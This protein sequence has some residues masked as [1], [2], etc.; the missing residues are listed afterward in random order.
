LINANLGPKDHEHLDKVSLKPAAAQ[1]FDSTA[2]SA[3]ASFAKN[4]LVSNGDQFPEFEFTDFKKR[5]I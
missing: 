2:L 3:S 5:V 1:V 4:S